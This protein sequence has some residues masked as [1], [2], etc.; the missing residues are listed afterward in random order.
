MFL[1]R[2]A[3]SLS[4]AVRP[5]VVA[6]Y[7][8]MLC[9][10][11]SALT[12]VPLLMSVIAGQHAVMWRTAVVVGIL[13]AAGGICSRIRCTERIQTNE[14]LAVTAL[15]FLLA[16]LLMA[17]PLTGYGIGF[18]DAWFESVSAITTTGLSTLP[19]VEDK[20]WTFLFARAWMQW[21][22]GLGVVV[23]A[24]AMLVR[25]GISAKRLG[26]SE[27]EIDN[28]VGGTRAHARRVLAVYS[29]L[30]TAGILL[31]W[32]LGASLLDAVVHAFAAI[33]T[34]G[35]S[36]YDSSLAGF[37]S[38][39]IRAATTLMCFAGAVSFSW[40]YSSAYRKL[41]T[42]AGDVQLRALA[43]ACVLCTILLFLALR[44]SF[45]ADA[46]ALGHSAMMA[47]S[48]QTTAGF[49]SLPVPELPS[50]AKLVLICSM[51]IG[52][53][54]GSTAGGLKMLRFVIL[55]RLAQRLF[56]QASIPRRSEIPIRIG[57]FTLQSEDLA[58]A[59]GLA[60]AYAAVLVLSWLAFLAG[61]HDPLNSLFEVAS[62]TA[63][64]GLS[65]GVVAQDLS[66]ILKGVL[67]ADML[68]GR[69][70]ILAVLILIFP[71]TWFGRRREWRA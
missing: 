15:I 33:S 6:R 67:C 50:A 44:P 27:Q 70:E 66:P 61:G 13:A 64:A 53:E 16:S 40:Y 37:S 43:A 9:L 22:G 54:L 58:A 31:L 41:R 42:L 4:F 3:R 19:T 47:I 30:T 60:A 46:R 49:A 68:M 28:V 18:L 7:L 51:L 2:S 29:I 56:E 14:G 63:T 36:N 11:L 55:V 21:V 59:G 23:L 5:L 26:F 38:P 71:P 35:F 25:P 57:R 20:P 45:T 69:V 52:G 24:L 8:A 1:T 32:S 65:A 12:L 62:A 34:G 39:W 48:A 17:F 10:P